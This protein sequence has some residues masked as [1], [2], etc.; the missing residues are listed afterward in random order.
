MENSQHGWGESSSEQSLS[1]NPTV[2]TSRTQEI[3]SMRATAITST[4]EPDSIGTGRIGLEWL[5]VRIGVE[6][7]FREPMRRTYS[8]F[9]PLSHKVSTSV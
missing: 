4:S 1:K 9:A 8:Q 5:S 3:R 7:P 2:R 6:I